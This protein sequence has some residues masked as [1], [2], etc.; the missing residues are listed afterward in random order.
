MGV[1]EKHTVLLQRH[2]MERDHLEDKDVD[3]EIFK[4]ALKKWN[5]SASIGPN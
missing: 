4:W 3:E 1:K 2:V 5:G